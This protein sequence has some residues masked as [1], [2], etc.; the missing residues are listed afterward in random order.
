MKSRLLHLIMT[1]LTLSLLSLAVVSAQNGQSPVLNVDMPDL[2]T[3]PLLS[4]EML[5]PG[6]ELTSAEAGVYQ[7]ICE[8]SDSTTPAI[9]TLNGDLLAVGCEIITPEAGV[10]I[11]DCN[12]DPVLPAIPVIPANIMTQPGEPGPLPGDFAAAPDACSLAA[13]SYMSPGMEAIRSTII[14]YDDIVYSNQDETLVLY[15]LYALDATELLPARN[16][17]ASPAN[18]TPV[19]AFNDGDIVTMG[20]ESICLTNEIFTLRL[21]QLESGEWV[22]DTLQVHEAL[23]LSDSWPENT[24]DP[25]NPGQTLAAPDNP[26]L[27]DGVMFRYL[28]PYIEPPVT[29]RPGGNIGQLAPSDEQL[30]V[31]EHAAPSYLAPGML[32]K[33]DGY[34]YV[35]YPQDYAVSNYLDWTFTNTRFD[36]NDHG[37]TTYV[38]IFNSTPLVNIVGNLENAALTVQELYS[39]NPTIATVLDGP[40]CT[41]T[42]VD[43]RFSPIDGSPEAP[44][45]AADRFY[46]WWEIEVNGQIGYYP[47]NVGQYSWWL[48]DFNEGFARKLFLYYMVPLADETMQAATCNPPILFAGQN[49]QP[50]AGAMNLR[51]APNGDIIGRV[52]ANQVINV[53]GEPVCEGGTNWWRT[54]RGGYIAESNPETG[55]RLLIPAVPTPVPTVEDSNPPPRATAVPPRPTQPRPTSEPSRPTP[56]PTVCDPTTGSCR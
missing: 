4:S 37:L 52:E 51:A 39:S 24:P 16:R 34:G 1:L 23:D 5:A 33:L 48:W 41:S 42:S 46:T 7:V 43:P 30:T 26:V 55:I 11:M 22:I 53:F 3:S 17:F 19:G 13:G 25:Q 49:V 40:F 15:A 35:K 18:L 29:T 36:L 31:C 8:D 28:L 44:D 20:T 27:V 6:C 45:P 54:G 21:W 14:N 2:S 12:D 56:V 10:Y 32:V 47:E 50:V 9:P 38:D